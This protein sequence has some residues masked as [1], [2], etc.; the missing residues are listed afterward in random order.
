MQP[1]FRIKDL[2]EPVID[3]YVMPSID[4]FK[5]LSDNDK[6]SLKE[7]IKKRFLL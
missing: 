1:I 2:W 3:G 4:E 7:L 6:E 5:K